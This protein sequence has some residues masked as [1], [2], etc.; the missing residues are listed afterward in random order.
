[1]GVDAPPLAP[2]TGRRSGRGPG[3]ALVNPLRRRHLDPQPEHLGAS[4]REPAEFLFG[5]LG[6]RAVKSTL[7]RP[8]IRWFRLLGIAV[9]A[10][11]LGCEPEPPPIAWQRV[12]LWTEPAVVSWNARDGKPFEHRDAPLGREEVRDL[13]LVPPSQLERFPRQSAS[14]ARILVQEAGSMLSFRVSL[15]SDAYLSFTPYPSPGRPANACFERGSRW[16]AS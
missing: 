8:S 10:L 5:L 1:M 16:T 15:G 14:L 6:S 3:R 2:A 13:T 12:D 7:K 11:A 9:F 4:P